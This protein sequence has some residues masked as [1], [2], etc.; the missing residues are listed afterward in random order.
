MKIEAIRSRLDKLPQGTFTGT[1]EIDL[2]AIR[3]DPTMQVGDRLDDRNKQRLRWSYKAVSDVP[4]LLLAFVDDNDG[5][6]IVIDGHHRFNV[7]A[8][9]QSEGH[10]QGGKPINSVQ[11]KFVRLTGEEARHQAAKANS[12][13][14][15]QLTSSESRR[16]FATYVG[17]GRHMHGNGRF[18]S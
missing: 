8:T 14:D 16:V 1:F 12:T 3:T 4:P 7:L 17:A 13:P 10:L 18:K 6:P 5:G 15:L 2:G 11:A 9:L